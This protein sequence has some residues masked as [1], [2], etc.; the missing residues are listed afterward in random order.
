[1]HPTSAF[2]CNNVWTGTC[3][4]GTEHGA[5]S[6]AKAEGRGRTAQAQCVRGDFPSLRLVLGRG[7]PG[8]VTEFASATGAHAASQARPS[9]GLT[10]HRL[11][12][13]LCRRASGAGAQ[14]VR[15]LPVPG[16]PRNTLSSPA[17]NAASPGPTPG[18]GRGGRLATV[19][20]RSAS[21]EDGDSHP[22]R[23]FHPG[24]STPWWLLSLEDVP[25]RPSRPRARVQLGRWG[26]R[27]AL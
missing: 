26:Q 1:M 7:A 9:P 17:W 11:H 12:G 10:G 25:L 5:R 15:M 3:P 22:R 13:A 6:T 21:H 27:H 19:P 24:A 8:R 23:R 16:V 2:C 4:V 18:A 20:G 14:A